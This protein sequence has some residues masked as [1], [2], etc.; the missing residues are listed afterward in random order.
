MPP[1]L[2][3]DISLSH[4]TPQSISSLFQQNSLFIYLFHLNKTK[5]PTQ[6]SKKGKEMESEK[7]KKF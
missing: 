6:N 2:F 1:F 3:D 7:L 5:K 4:S